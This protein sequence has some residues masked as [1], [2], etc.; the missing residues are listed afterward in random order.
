MKRL[1]FEAVI[2]CSS[3]TIALQNTFDHAKRSESRSIK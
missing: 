1:Y 3:V 2:I